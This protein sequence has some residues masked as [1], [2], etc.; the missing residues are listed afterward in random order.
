VIGAGAAGLTAASRLAL[1]SLRVV[2]LEARKRIG[3]R[4]LWTG[5]SD[6]RESVELGAEFIHGRAPETMELFRRAGIAAVE[7]DRESWVR[8][9]DGVLMK[10]DYDFRASTVIFA[11][12]H[13]LDADESVEHY[14]Q[15][16]EGD[17][18]IAATV[19]LARAF[20]EGFDAADP[21]IA[22]V[23]GIADELRSG[24]DYATHRPAEGYAPLFDE[25]RRECDDAG[26]TIVPSAVARAVKWR[27]GEVAVKSD[28]AAERRTLR[29]RAAV[30]CLPV[31]VM[32]APSNGV[33]FD[34]EL[35]KAK[36]SALDKIEMGHVVKVGLRFRS[37]LWERIDHGRYRDSSFFR[38]PRGR[39]PA[40]WTRRPLLGA[41]VIAWAGGT[42]AMALKGLTS[43]E[44][45][46]IAFDEF[47]NLF[48]DS[49]AAREEFV[50]GVMHD[51][52]ND[53]FARGAYS[54]VTVGGRGAR[55]AL[56]SPVDDTLFFAGEATS[57]DGQGGTVN[58][59]IATGGRAAREAA[60]VL[61]AELR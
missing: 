42:Q 39:F 58:G 29:A 54:Y 40:Y 20:V 10:D 17:P 7:L 48:G 31:G 11:R 6:G 9:R 45:I 21:S 3:G 55:A 57:L 23:I 52:S 47:S 14:L 8:D 4:V 18:S 16:F 35:P 2:V 50:D 46:A 33:S 43:S 41:S 32:K 30:I 37:P 12:A 44:L 59:A 27:R 36:S 24:V 28:V 19:D 38:V 61:C 1:R 13:D 51:W 49:R 5:S 60:A 26:V 22:S 25:L 56:G 53:P 15:R 34:P